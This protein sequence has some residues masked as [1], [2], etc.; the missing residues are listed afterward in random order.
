MDTYAYEEHVISNVMFRFNT[1]QR[2]SDI[3]NAV[4]Y[5]KLVHDDY[6]AAVDGGNFL[7]EETQVLT[8]IISPFTSRA[9]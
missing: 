4:F 5:E 9:A 7:V 6:D 8:V 2:E 3:E 1:L